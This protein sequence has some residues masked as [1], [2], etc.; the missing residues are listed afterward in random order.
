MLDS[1]F[2]VLPA[3]AWAYYRTHPI[4]FIEQMI[5]KPHSESRGKKLFL[6]DQ[7][8]SV[9]EAIA[10]G[11]R[12]TVCSGRGCGKTALLAMIGL[13]F[14]S[15][16]QEAQ[17]V[18]SAPSSK[19]LKSGLMVEYALWGR[20]SYLE[21]LL[22]FT[23]EKIYIN[24]KN[25]VGSYGSF[26]EPRTASSGSPEAM[27]GIHAESLMIQLDEASC[28]PDNII[29]TL[30]ATLT[31][32]GNNK[33]IM[34][35][36]GT[37]TSGEFY[38]S[39]M[40][41][42]SN[43]WNKFRLSALD[44]PFTSKESAEECRLRYGEDSNLYKIDVLGLF[45]SSDPDSF[46]DFHEVVAAF[47]RDVVPASTDEIEI[48]VDPARFGNDNTVLIWRQ[49]MKV[50][51]PIFKGKT[52]VVDVADMVKELVTSIRSQT[53]YKDK[54][55][56][57]IDVGGLGAGVYDILELDRLHNIDPVECNFGGRGDDRC[58]N[59]ASVMWNTL[60][61]VIGQ[62]SLPDESECSNYT[63]VKYMR[64]ELTARRCNYDTGKIKVE[65]K[66]V[67]KK[68]FGRSPDY[69]DALVLCFAR[70]K[71]QRSFL[72][73]FDHLSDQYVVK[74]MTYLNGL[75]H[76]VSVHYTSD[77]QASVVWAY[78]GNGTLYIVNESLTDDNVARVA[79]EINARSSVKPNKI[80][81]N[82]RCFGSGAGAGQDIR[83]QLR[84][85][86][87]QLRENFKY[88]ELGALELLN[89]LV[90][91]KSIKLVK[92]C[93]NTIQQLDKWNSDSS[94]A[95]A[96]KDY[97]LCYAILNIVSELKNKISPPAKKVIPRQSY[98]GGTAQTNNQPLYNKALGW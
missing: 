30:V 72:T 77:R 81:G 89:Q 85:Y 68:E 16:H 38:D 95:Q 76:Y 6:S 86:R 78:W 48:G 11:R 67:F 92:N 71:N 14:I 17:L 44:S 5:L 42:R 34:T 40:D 36:N 37:R 21:G 25:P 4:E 64:E 69:A 49:G 84:K 28:I 58:A 65:T 22:E 94:R 1:V 29:R 53:G 97:G 82:D 88:D 3:E 43:L 31:S 45:G 13:W 63:V 32:G 23:T 46:L 9:I 56:V 83:A 8:K 15:C 96:E 47:D 50:H 66:D 90:S 26:I 35:S 41:D 93:R 18:A 91:T 59:E 20:G 62:I 73:D 98:A 10:V 7:Q 54:I 2:Y 39:H 74:G 61:D 12:V 80:L 55:R 79:S 70:K 57:K 51:E 60:R 52:S 19:T 33:I 27:S 75:D 87:V 24:V